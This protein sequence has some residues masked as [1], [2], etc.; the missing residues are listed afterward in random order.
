MAQLYCV[1]PC[2]IH[3]GIP[4]GGG[5]QGKT[6]AFLGHCEDAP[7]VQL[8]PASEPVFCSLGGV[9]VPF[10]KS[11][12]SEEGFISLDLT[13]YNQLIVDRIRQRAA[14]STTPVS[15]PGFFTSDDMGTLMIQENAAFEVWL[16]FPYAIHPA[17]AAGGMMPGY[18]F[19][20]CDP[21][22]PDDLGP[23]GTRARKEHLAFHAIPKYDY[24]TGRLT[25]YDYD[26]TGLTAIN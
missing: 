7:Q 18:H 6:K 23:L 4:V 24:A 25:L 13:R 5:L 16:V 21:C 12:Q 22:G 10:D 17:M 15:Q 20:A 1:G 19:W 11:F 3:V 2:A 8:R 9:K 26:T 14:F